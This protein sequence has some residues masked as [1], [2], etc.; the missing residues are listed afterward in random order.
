MMSKNTNNSLAKQKYICKNVSK[1]FAV[2]LFCLFFSISN[3]HSQP[4]MTTFTNKN[5]ANKDNRDKNNKATVRNQLFD[6]R[7]NANATSA[8][9]RYDRNANDIIT[10]TLRYSDS[11]GEVHT[12]LYTS[13]FKQQKYNLNIGYLG[14]KNLYCYATFPFIY[15]TV[16]ER[17]TFD[18]TLTARIPRNKGSK[19]D[20]EG[21]RFDAGYCFNFDFL[22]NVNLTVL[23]GIFLPFNKYNSINDAAIIDSTDDFKIGNKKI[24]LGRVFE[25]L[26]G[27]KFDFNFHPVRMQLGGIYNTRSK[28]F[29]DK[30]HL[31][32]LIG[33]TNIADT[34]LF[35]NFRYVTSIGDYEEKY[36]VN[37]WRQTLWEN[38]F[39]V[40]L[41]FTIFITEEVYAN[42]GYTIRLW[43]ENTLS[44]KTIGINLG[45]IIR[46]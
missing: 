18:S 31:N 40:D 32:F 14:V 16:E 44:H 26:I 39:D 23:G 6:F 41:G 36:I 2:K 30:L 27:T 22:Q 35:A 38:Y 24:E 12:Y 28:D 3:L 10:D 1:I 11:L 25:G 21:L 34:E 13:D 20:A 45:Y 7:L 5:N 8:S 42:L 43:G 15:T 9:M 4:I 46:K 29:A 37:F 19:F 17:F 33:F